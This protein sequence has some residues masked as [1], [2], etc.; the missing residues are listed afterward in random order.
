[1]G[2]QLE[3]VRNRSFWVDLRILAKTAKTLFAGKMWTKRRI[4]RELSYS[5][6]KNNMQH[7]ENIAKRARKEILNMIYRTK[8][9]HIGSSL[10]ITVISSININIT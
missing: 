6:T 1:M 9:P 8:S 4:E 7:Y 5:N 2:S 3:H 10:S